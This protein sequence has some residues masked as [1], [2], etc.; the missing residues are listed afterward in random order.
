MHYEK[1]EN[2]SRVHFAFGNTFTKL[3]EIN[4]RMNNSI[5]SKI[6]GGGAVRLWG[7]KKATEIYLSQESMKCKLSEYTQFM[8]YW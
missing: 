3:K 2:N 8:G 1:R 6:K 5:Y 4:P 7:K